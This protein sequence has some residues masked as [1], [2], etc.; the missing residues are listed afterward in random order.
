[1]PFDH[2]R[3]TRRHLSIVLGSLL[4][5]VALAGCGM[6]GAGSATPRQGGAKI[7][8]LTEVGKASSKMLPRRVLGPHD[9]RPVDGSR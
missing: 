2:P 5:A 7:K 6:E 9:M 1:M 4:C 3:F 8:A